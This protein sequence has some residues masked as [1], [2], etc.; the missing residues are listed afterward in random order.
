LLNLSVST[1][2]LWRGGRVG[3]FLFDFNLDSYN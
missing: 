3:A 2:P 1:P